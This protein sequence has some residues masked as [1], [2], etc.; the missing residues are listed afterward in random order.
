MSFFLIVYHVVLVSAVYWTA[1]RTG[2]NTCQ[3]ESRRQAEAQTE[4]LKEILE[5]LNMDA[6]ALMNEKQDDKRK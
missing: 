4:P 1:Y 6:E 3:D 2:Y 5:R